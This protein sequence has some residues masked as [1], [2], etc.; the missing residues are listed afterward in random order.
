MGSESLGQAVANNTNWINSVIA[1]SKLTSQLA[2]ELATISSLA[3]KIVIQEG[4]LDAKYANARTVRGYRGNWEADTNNPILSNSSGVVGDVYKVSIGGNIDIGSG[5]INYV[6]GDLIYLSEDNWIKISPNQIS[7]IT[8]LQLALDALADGLIPQGTWDATLNDPDIDGGTAETGYFWIVSVAGSTDVGGITDWEINDWA[9]KTATGWAKIDNTDKVL[10]V[11]GRTGIIVLSITDITGLTTALANTVKI[12][13]DQDIEGE[14]TFKDDVRVYNGNKLLFGTGD[15]L[16]IYHDGT[17]SYIS[18]TGTGNLE[19]SSNLLKVLSPTGENMIVAQQ[20]ASVRLFFDDSKKIETTTTGATI[21]GS[22]TVTNKILG[23]LDTTVIGVTQAAENNSTLIATTAYADAAAGSAV[24]DYLPLTGGILTGNVRFNDNI[25]ALFGTSSDL[26]IYHDGSHNF[27]TGSPNLYVQTAGLF[28]VE[29][30]SEVDMIRATA[31][32]A[33]ELFHAGTRVFTTDFNGVRVGSQTDKLE[34]VKSSGN[35][36]ITN[37]SNNF[38][39]QQATGFVDIQ[40]STSVSMARFTVGGDVKLFQ[41]GIVKLITDNNG[42]KVIGTDSAIPYVTIDLDND[43]SPEVLGE[44]FGGMRLYSGKTPNP[45][46]K[47]QAQ[48]ITGKNPITNVLGA[49]FQVNVNQGGTLSEAFRIN[50][51]GNAGFG[52][53]QPEAKVHVYDINAELRLED[54]EGGT[55][56]A[57]VFTGDNNGLKLGAGTS[58]QTVVEITGDN[59]IMSLFG[60]LTFNNQDASYTGNQNYT[61]RIR[62]DNTSAI[63]LNPDLYF[64]KQNPALGTEYVYMRIAG[65]GGAVPTVYFPTSV[66]ISGFDLDIRGN[67]AGSGFIEKGL[68]MQSA[69]GTSYRITVANDGTVTSTAT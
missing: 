61:Y 21:T 6:A 51:G 52:L 7:D 56:F 33:V 35:A 17:N 3:Q 4:E 47:A 13:T 48:F 39:I 1:K 8:G 18:D 58:G 26:K 64:T 66:I 10:S 30:I 41:N 19:L 25:R 12:T 36:R 50:V 23:V 22:L 29:T 2:Q 62:P 55:G 28:N 68:I 63:N 40:S 45:G 60:T 43:T 49:A 37:N 15:D 9:V 54:S 38:L 53:T 24:G 67:V 34:I 14:K 59:R 69:N 44:V 57:R 20:G 32:D 16:K 42:I 11:A 31:G 65:T 46:I 5:S 27:I